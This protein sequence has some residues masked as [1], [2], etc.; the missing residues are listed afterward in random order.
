MTTALVACDLDGQWDG[1]FIRDTPTKEWPKQ[2]PEFSDRESSLG[3]WIGRLPAEIRR[4]V[5]AYVLYV[6]GGI[7]IGEPEP[8]DDNDAEPDPATPSADEESSE[9]VDE[10]EDSDEEDTDMEF[11][12]PLF[13][14]IMLASHL[15]YNETLPVM[16]EVN[17]I[18]LREKSK[19]RVSSNLWF[20]GWLENREG[21]YRCV[22]S[23]DFQEY[24][25]TKELYDID[26]FNPDAQLMELCTNLKHV[27]VH[28]DHYHY[29][30]PRRAS[31]EHDRMRWAFVCKTFDQ[32]VDKWRGE[33]A[34]R[35]Y[36]RKESDRMKDT[37][38]LDRLGK[39]KTLK[40]LEIVPSAMYYRQD[41]GK[42]ADFFKLVN[43]NLLQSFRQWLGPHT[44]I[45]VT[46]C[47]TSVTCNH[48]VQTI[49]MMRDG[50]NGNIVTT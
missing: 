46:P 18:R 17:T 1:T 34:A 6:E 39:V 37:Y 3:P 14:P 29:A 15:I 49:S 42:M 22:R 12:Y 20:L 41:K 26:E 13:A 40:L 4:K 23:I 10:I 33:N 44:Q 9:I 27:T 38:Q 24:S 48:W 47:R 19:T 35:T 31:P 50:S 30:L 2:I 7:I 8:E 28:L 32:A 16:L 25:V 36:A 5:W 11:S 43:D 45:V 21:L